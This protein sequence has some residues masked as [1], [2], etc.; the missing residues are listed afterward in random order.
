MKIYGEKQLFPLKRM[1]MYFNFYFIHWQ[2]KRWKAQCDVPP[3]YTYHI[4]MYI[5]HT[6]VSVNKAKI[7]GKQREQEIQSENWC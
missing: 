2:V 4:R 5:L 3:Y 6:H 7:G 1:P